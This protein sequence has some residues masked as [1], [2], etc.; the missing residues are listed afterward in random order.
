MTFDKVVGVTSANVGGYI[1][2]DE[3][4]TKHLE[5]IQAVIGRLSTDSFLMKAWALTIAGIFFG[6]AVNTHSRR[7]GLAAVVPT[8]IFWGLDTYFLRCERLFRCLY[9][10]VR[11]GGRVEP[12]FMNATDKDFI[13]GLAGEREQRAASRW[14]AFRSATLGLYYGGILTSAVLLTFLVTWTKPG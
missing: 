7:L 5:M 1:D 13:R 8:C 3:R 10:Q 14:K 2:F 6:F 12:F 9:D 11:L 4:R